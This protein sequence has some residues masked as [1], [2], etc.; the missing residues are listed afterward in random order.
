MGKAELAIE[1]AERAI[2]LY[3]F[4]SHNF[5][6]YHA[7]AIT[8]FSRRRYQDAIDAAQNAVHYNPHFGFARGVLAA[9]LLRVGCVAEAKA[10]GR[11][12]LECEPTFTI[13]A[14]SAVEFDPAVFEP[15]IEALRQ[16]GLPE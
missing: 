6:S 5:R 12:I 2:R 13:H 8:S 3:P 4:D 15:F 10:A 14:F 11:D 7:L 9:A 16:V 1:R